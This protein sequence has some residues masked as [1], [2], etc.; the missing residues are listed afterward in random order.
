MRSVAVGSQRSGRTRTKFR[1]ASHFVRSC[2]SHEVVQAQSIRTC[3][4]TSAIPI[5][6][7]SRFDQFFHHRARAVASCRKKGR[8][9]H[10]NAQAGL[11][12]LGITLDADERCGARPTLRSQ[13]LQHGSADLKQISPGV[14][15]PGFVKPPTFVAVASNC[16]PDRLHR[17]MLPT[18][19]PASLPVRGSL[20]TAGRPVCWTHPV[21]PSRPTQSG[22]RRPARPPRPRCPPPS[23]R[24]PAQRSS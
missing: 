15:S 2:A 18:M 13:A 7:R 24:P 3:C 19:S 1:Q 21:R 8:I 14:I 12:R 5:A 22:H 20:P 6:R 11:A 9:R 16:G 17:V 23:P 4:R 10:G